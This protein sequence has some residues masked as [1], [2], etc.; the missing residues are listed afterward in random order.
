VTLLTKQ[1]RGEN[2][3]WDDIVALS[4]YGKQIYTVSWNDLEEKLEAFQKEDN[5]NLDPDF[6][7]D[8]VWSQSQQ[9]KYVE[10]ILKRGHLNKDIIFNCPGWFEGHKGQMVLIDGKQRLQAAR[11]FMSNQLPVFGN[12]YRKDFTRNGKPMLLFSHQINFTFNINDL[13]TREEILQLYLDINTGGV[14]HSDD[15]ISKVRELLAIEK[16]KTINGV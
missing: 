2:M 14:I 5:L 13:E 11:S 12:T 6:Q 8:H 15:E 4:K 7:R 9:I 3:E 16:A 10:Y 1:I